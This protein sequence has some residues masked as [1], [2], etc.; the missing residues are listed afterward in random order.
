VILWIDAHLSPALA[1]WLGDTSGV[2][3]HAVRDLGLREAKDLPIFHTA[4]EAGAVVVS[5]EQSTTWE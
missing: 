4:R 5:K 2:T 3:P 1:H